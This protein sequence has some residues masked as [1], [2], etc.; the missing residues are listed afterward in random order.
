[1]RRSYWVYRASEI[2]VNLGFKTFY[3][4]HQ[5]GEIPSG[6]C[7]VLP[8]HQ[9]KLDILLEGH[10]IYRA[11]G[12]QPSFIMKGF[13]FPLNH[14]LQ[15]YGGILVARPKDLRKG[16]I[17][18]DEAKDVN[19]K[20]ASQTIELLRQGQVVVAHP[21]GTRTEGRIG[22]IKMALLERIVHAETGA[23]FVLMGIEYDGRN[24][25]VRTGDPFYTT[26]AKALE[27]HIR[28]ELP[29]L[30]GL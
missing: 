3:N 11:T 8:K 6:P 16:K 2:L 27:D 28:R 15:L 30:S 26:D 21:E 12:K 7:I 25:T 19:G 4:I 24:I 14:F 18:K 1:M 20:A 23:P 10:V 9:R 22:P 5:E 29:R 17:T 13:P